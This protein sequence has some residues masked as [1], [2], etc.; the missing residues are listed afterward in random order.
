M[1]EAGFRALIILAKK[2]AHERPCL[3]RTG[4]LSEEF[5]ISQPTASRLLITLERKKL[6][7]RRVRKGGQEVIITKNGLAALR[8][9]YEDLA[10]IFERRRPIELRG[11]IVDGSGEGKYYMSQDGYVRQF[12]SKLGF[13][14]FPGTLNVRLEG[15]Y[16]HIKKMLEGMRGMEIEGFRTEERTFG[17][18]KCFHA[19][20]KGI[21]AALVMPFRTHHDEVVEV[22]APVNLRESLG[23]REG[24]K[25]KVEVMAGEE[26]AN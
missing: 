7:E 26:S 16:L 2:G 21:E 11:I 5:G 18:V 3:L 19:K 25:I 20:V 17:A 8:A 4:D 10:S 15:S 22:V 6:I 14:P 23:L 13:Q 1:M 9:T 24:D 12:A